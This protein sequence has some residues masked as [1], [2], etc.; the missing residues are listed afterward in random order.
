[1]NDQFNQFQEEQTEIN[2]KIKEN[3]D[4]EVINHK[5]DVIINN[6]IESEIETIQEQ[7]ETKLFQQKQSNQNKINELEKQ[8]DILKNQ[9]NKKDLQENEEEY[10]M[11]LFKDNCVD[12]HIEI[13]SNNDTCNIILGFKGRYSELIKYDL[14]LQSLKY[15]EEVLEKTSCKIYDFPSKQG[16]FINPKICQYCFLIHKINDEIYHFAVFGADDDEYDGFIISLFEFEVDYHQ[17]CIDLSPDLLF[18]EQDPMYSWIRSQYI[19]IDVNVLNFVTK[20]S[21]PRWF[22][23]LLLASKPIFI[24]SILKVD[25]YM[26][27]YSR[28]EISGI[29]IGGKCLLSDKSLDSLMEKL[30]E[31]KIAHETNNYSPVIQKTSDSLNIV[32]GIYCSNR[33]T[34]V[35]NNVFTENRGVFYC[36]E[37]HANT[38]GKSTLNCSGGDQLI[39]KLE[40]NNNINIILGQNARMHIFKCSIRFN[41]FAAYSN[42]IIFVENYRDGDIEELKKIIRNGK[43]VYKHHGFTQNCNGIFPIFLKELTYQ[44]DEDKNKR[45]SIKYGAKKLP[46]KKITH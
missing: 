22:H 30:E 6:Q 7:F 5:N 12:I 44:N 34:I 26:M 33:C 14:E 41:Y 29:F 16:F 20:F 46:I 10:F 9:N 32:T 4:S 13:P 35:E 18:D 38:N 45:K 19:T 39:K 15:D 42:S 11:K 24:S 43:I 23:W 36:D 8:I 2:N 31:I 40:G 28:K 25:F 17:K 1:M 37:F 21:N 27:K 3:I